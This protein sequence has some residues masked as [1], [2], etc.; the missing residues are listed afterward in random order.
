MATMTTG[1][2]RQLRKKQQ[3]TSDSFRASQWRKGAP[4]SRGNN[5]AGREHDITPLSIRC[6]TEPS[7]GI[8]LRVKAG[9]Q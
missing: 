1:L 3:S 5:C 7:V 6:I 4:E 2:L 9:S 8:S